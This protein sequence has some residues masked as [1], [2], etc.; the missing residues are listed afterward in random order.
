M[1]FNAGLIF[2]LVLLTRS[3]AAPSGPATRYLIF[4]VES[5]TEDEQNALIDLLNKELTPGNYEITNLTRIG[6]Q[7]VSAN[8]T[9]AQISNFNTSSLVSEVIPDFHLDPEFGRRSQYESRPYDILEIQ[10][11]EEPEGSDWIAE[12]YENLERRAAIHQ[13][14]ALDELK[15]FSQ[16]P[17]TKL[18]DVKSYTYDDSAGEDITVYVLDSGYYIKNGEYTGL[19]TAPRWI[20]AGR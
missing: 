1:K 9:A 13:A 17:G 3:S 4:P 8:L 12:A 5:A 14:K 16:P 20:F 18:S 19:K 10:E 2:S 11:V 15:V 7:F 6:L